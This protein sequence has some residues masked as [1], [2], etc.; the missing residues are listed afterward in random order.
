MERTIHLVVISF[1]GV[2]KVIDTRESRSINQCRGAGLVGSTIRVD[3]VHSVPVPWFIFC[4]HFSSLPSS[5]LSEPTSPFLRSTDVGQ[6]VV[7]RR[8]P[9]PFTVTDRVSIRVFPIRCLWPVIEETKEG[10][11]TKVRFCF[12]SR[13]RSRGL[14]L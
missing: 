4:L 12:Q 9:V 5:P 10:L 11:G 1:M 6:K 8:F 7:K 2:F 14:I 3:V 13:V